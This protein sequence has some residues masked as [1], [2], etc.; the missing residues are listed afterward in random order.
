MSVFGGKADLIHCP[1][2]SLLLAEA[3]EKV[4]LE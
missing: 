3:V 1:A 4:G 2:K